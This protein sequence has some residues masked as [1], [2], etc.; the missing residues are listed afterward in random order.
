MPSMGG[1]N[2]FQASFSGLSGQVPPS[3][4][5]PSMPGGGGNERDRN[6]GTNVAGLP[7]YGPPLPSMGGGGYGGQQQQQQGQEPWVGSF[8]NYQNWAG[9]FQAEH[10]RAPGEQDY[11]DLVDS[12]NFLQQTGRAPS[13]RE[14]LNRYYTGTW[15]GT[16]GGGGYGGGGGGRGYGGYSS[17]MPAGWTPGMYFWNYGR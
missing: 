15:S 4:A 3:Y 5:Q 8:G 16:G 6:Q 1:Y 12:Q 14:W 13:Q 7:M 9:Q 2:P 10:G 11:Y 17:S